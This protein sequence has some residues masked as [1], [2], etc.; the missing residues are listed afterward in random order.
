MSRSE[1]RVESPEPR[2]G[3]LRAYLRRFFT[4]WVSED[5]TPAYSALDRSD[6]LD[7]DP[8]PVCQPV[9]QVPESGEVVDHIRS[10]DRTRSAVVGRSRH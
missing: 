6:G 7:Q 8:D 10:A 4:C 5:P 1:L 2:R 3:G 9:V